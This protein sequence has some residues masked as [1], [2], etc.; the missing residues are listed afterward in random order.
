M[1]Q[2]RLQSYW[3]KTTRRSKI[4]MQFIIFSELLVLSEGHL[5][6]LATQ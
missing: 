2:Y 6:A 4:I 3:Q 1:R 5:I